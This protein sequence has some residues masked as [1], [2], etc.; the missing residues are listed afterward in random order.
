M[1]KGGARDVTI[2]SEVW[3]SVNEEHCKSESTEAR[4]FKERPVLEGINKPQTQRFSSAW[5]ASCR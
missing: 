1:G 5:L 2:E 4:R 3:L